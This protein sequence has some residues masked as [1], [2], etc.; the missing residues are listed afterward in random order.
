MSLFSQHIQQRAD[1]SN[2]SGVVQVIPS[3]A[4]NDGGPSASVAAMANSL[5]AMECPTVIRAVRSG[6]QEGNVAQ[7]FTYRMSCSSVGR[8]FKMSADLYSALSADAENGA[9]LHAH[10]L[11]LMP[12]IY[13]AWVKRK[14]SNKVML[15]HSSHGMLAEAALSFSAAKKRLFWNLV[16]R[17]A[18][19][20]ADC[21]HATA[22]SEYEE[23]RAAGM[24][25]AIAIIPNGIEIPDIAGY[26]RPHTRE[27][28]A[29]SLGRIHP[30]KGLDRLIRAWAQLEDSHSDW[31]LRIIGPAER[32]HDEELRALAN[33]LGVKRLSIEGGIYSD[34]KIAAYRAADIF[35]LPTLNENFAM[36]VAEALAAEVPVISTKGAPWR[37][38]R[39]ERCGWWIDH[40]TE[41]LR[42]A[43]S[44]A[45]AMPRADLNSMGAR[46]RLWVT[47]DFGSDKLARAMSEVYYWLKNGGTPPPSVNTR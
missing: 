8:R 41:A 40:G 44:I 7:L 39:T 32:S 4:I 3:M 26:P 10:G 2:K 25:G 35:V 18:L 38:L 45:M 34:A 33:R 6:S 14:H 27:R 5:N 17:S 24:R 16:Q 37:G 28:T 30:K 15:I 11:W 22:P 31:R 19:D 29:L 21:L 9:I 20:S 36:T 47:R 42:G 1:R 12:N 46:G 43:L 23:L 13:P